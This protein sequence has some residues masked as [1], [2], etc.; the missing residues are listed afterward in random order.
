MKQ[1]KTLNLRNMVLIAM[2]SAVA[3]VLMFLEIPLPFIAPAFYEL[4]FSEVPVLIGTFSMGPVAGIVIELLKNLLHILIKGTSTAYVGELANF[5]VGC[6][7]VVPAGLIYQKAKSKKHALTG[8]IVGTVLMVAAGSLVNAYILLPWYANH[9]FA[10]AGGMDGILAA[11]A[12]VHA[13]AGTMM[14]F[15]MLCVAPFNLFKGIVVSAVTM[16]LYK[17]VSVVI[18]GHAA[19]NEAGRKP[20]KSHAAEI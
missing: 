13:G 15:V 2:L 9:F 6:A 10:G 4:D 19:E 14:G 7:L 5:L 16:L 12:A 18:K 20:K 3:F 11:G 8:M 1:N 17:R